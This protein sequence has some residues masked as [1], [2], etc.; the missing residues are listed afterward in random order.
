ML[1]GQAGGAVTVRVGEYSL[2]AIYLAID[3]LRN[4]ASKV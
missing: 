3:I 2:D 1:A 4:R